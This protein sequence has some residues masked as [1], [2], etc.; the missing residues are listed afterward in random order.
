MLFDM[1]EKKNNEQPKKRSI[2]GTLF[3]PDLGSDIRP[4]AQETRMFVRMLAM[5][6]ASNRLFPKDHPAFTNDKIRLTLSDVL[7]I[8]W[9]RLSW[10]KEGIP[11][12][13]LFIAVFGVLILS[14]LFVITFVLSLFAGTAHAADGTGGDS[15]FTPPNGTDKDWALNWLNYIFYG[16]KYSI[17]L[18]G[19]K[20]SGVTDSCVWQGA[21]G[22]ALGLYSQGILVLAGFILLY[23]LASMI[24]ETAHTGKP[25]G[26]ANQIWA[27]IRLVVA[28]GLLIPISSASSS[29]ACVSGLN[30]GQ[31]LVISIAKMGS[32]F[33]SN[34]WSKFVDVVTPKSTQTACQEGSPSCLKVSAEVKALGASMV[35]NYACIYIQNAYMSQLTTD[36]SWLAKAYSATSSALGSA[37]QWLND[38]TGGNLKLFGGTHIGEANYCGG[39]SLLSYPASTSSATASSSP[40]AAVFNSQRAV[41]EKYLSKFDT[42]ASS[43]YKYFV[44]GSGGSS[45]EPSSNAEIQS[46]LSEY[47]AELNSTLASSLQSADQT[48][49][50]KNGISDNALFTQGGWLTAGAWFNI[51]AK[52][53][54]DRAAA[55]RAPVAKVYVPGILLDFEKLGKKAPW[56]DLKG[57]ADEK[58]GITGANE[59][60]AVSLKKYEEWLGPRGEKSS[61]ETSNLAKKAFTSLS[62]A[63]GREDA[64]MSVLNA[65]NPFTAILGAVDY[66]LVATGAWSSEGWMSLKFDSSLNPLAEIASYGQN[67]ISSSLWCFTGMGVLAAVSSAEILGNGAGPGILVIA[68]ILGTFGMLLFGSGLSLGVLLP[69]MPFIRFFFG[70]LTWLLSVFEAVVCAPLFALAHLN[71]E[72]PGL[73]GQMA[74]GGYFFI[75]SLF[76]RPA[77][78]ILGLAAGF[79]M[80]LVAISFLNTMFV[81]AS[82]STGAQTASSGSLFKIIFTVVYCALVY[83]CG[84]TCFKTIGIF[85]QRALTWMGQSAHHEPMGDQNLVSGTT[86]AISTYLAGDFM[87]NIAQGPSS[88]IKERKDA[89]L[90]EKADAGTQKRHEEMLEGMAKLT[91]NARGGGNIGGGGSSAQ[92]TPPSSGGGNDQP[93]IQSAGSSGS[94][95][96]SDDQHQELQ[97]AAQNSEWENQWQD[98]NRG[99]DWNPTPP[100]GWQSPN[101]MGRSDQCWTGQGWELRKNMSQ[102]EQKRYD[103]LMRQFADKSNLNP[104]NN[105]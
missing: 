65:F 29:N 31:Y 10:T 18:S 102:N 26:N 51:I 8:S 85:P 45:A 21:L 96:R 38:K 54:A 86:A 67:L 47:E 105:A 50:T 3:N 4:L 41:F 73:P 39:Y 101:S 95:G 62:G 71:P 100:S 7:S 36:Q 63:G 33:A 90:K 19:P 98:F 27:P 64:I 32:G 77:M 37:N 72:G 78:M 9:N 12:I 49:K 89:A 34:V 83:I 99:A 60:T 57:K 42:K 56:Y 15:M 35:L 40:Y 59:R 84:N 80:F 61:G 48:A 70:S 17:D 76:I 82:I 6:L 53:Q 2:W 94:G 75:L 24:A 93:L 87:K 58:A 46:L 68:S 20:A 97:T 74:R 22:N 44:K 52:N 66:S 13:A 11:Q 5:I 43:T 16:Q 69:L 1:G 104:K 79:L 91:E 55:A 103:D 28:I 25:M 88:M 81:V 23:H 14:A 92:I 30:T